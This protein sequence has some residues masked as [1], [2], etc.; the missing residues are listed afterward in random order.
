MKE[1]AE[2]LS[3]NKKTGI[4]LLLLFT[5]MVIFVKNDTFLYKET[6]AKIISVEN[7]FSHKEEG[8]NDEE[9]RYYD[10]KM[11]AVILNGKH[12]GKKLTI[13]NT[14]SSS[15]V[16]DEKYTKGDVVFVSPNSSVTSGTITQKKRDT[17]IVTLLGIFL[18]LL[19]FLNRKHGIMVCFSLIIN[20][21]IFFVSLGKYQQGM[22]MTGIAFVMMLVFSVL[23]L[24]FAGGFHKKTWVAIAASLVTT[25]ICYGIYE[26]TLTLN[27]RLPYE[28]MEYAVNP[29]DLSDLFLVGILMGSLGAVMDVSISIT[30]GVQEILGTS[31]DISLKA[32]I[33]SIR[34]M[35]YDIMGTMINVLL[36]TYISG[37]IPLVV[38]KIDNGYTLYHLIHFHLIFE[39]VR[40]LMG[41]I[42]IVMA[43]PVAGFFSVIVLYGKNLKKRKKTT[44]REQEA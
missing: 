15:G 13:R 44:D 29:D 37:A 7:E 4:L 38:I 31:P 3:I 19:F 16:N 42:G 34:E 25:M 6:I 27:E 26:I 30:S 21:G 33:K 40:F 8:P 24:L 39:I 2:Y 11:T 23:T 9:E 35:G 17:Y 12:N 22:D 36:F 28:M 14:Y 43:I 1:F 41:G 10:Q 20:L 5:V 32:L 18:F